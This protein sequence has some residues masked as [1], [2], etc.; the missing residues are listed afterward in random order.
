MKR[1]RR[2]VFLDKDG[3]LVRDV[4]YSVDPE[5]LEF[6]AGAAEGLG[7]LHAAGYA[8]VV[9]SNQPGL[10]LGHFTAGAFAALREAL[11]RQVRQQC[12][13]PL[14]AM[15]HCP[16]APATPLRPG[17]GCRKPE[18]GMLLEAAE[19][20]G[21]DLRRSWMIGDILDDV[22]AGHRAGTRSLLLDVGNETVWE[23]GPLR[24]PDAVV[25]DLAAAARHILE[26]DR[27]PARPR[28][29]LTEGAA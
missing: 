13:V 11:L 4:P 26:A 8:L 23:R 10:A 29:A 22:E 1:L 24:E 5:R 12:G 15:H 25:P 2:A 21:L 6:T 7:A 28:R 18:P 27:P 17:C 16:H 9:V 20:H 14:L 19:R 3:T